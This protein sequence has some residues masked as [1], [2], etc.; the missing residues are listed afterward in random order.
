MSKLSNQVFEL[1]DSPVLFEKWLEQFEPD[2]TFAINTLN[3][4]DAFIQ[5]VLKENVTTD[6]CYFMAE[7]FRYHLPG[8]AWKTNLQLIAHEENGL[9]CAEDV[10]EVLKDIGRKTRDTDLPL[11]HRLLSSPEEFRQWLQNRPDRWLADGNIEDNCPLSQF[12]TERGHHG[13]VHVYCNS[14]TVVSDPDLEY[15]LPAWAA[16]YSDLSIETKY[17]LDRESALALLEQALQGE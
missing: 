10:L 1:L 2:Y 6:R 11:F 7:D 4:F 14:F 17:A 12:M 3:P 15:K 8:W 13:P 9:V 5:H 16:R